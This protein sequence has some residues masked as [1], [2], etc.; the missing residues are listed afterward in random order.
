VIGPAPRQAGDEGT[1]TAFVSWGQVSAVQTTIAPSSVVTLPVGSQGG[2]PRPL[3]GDPART[4][5][6]SRILGS[7]ILVASGAD[8][9]VE[10]IGATITVKQISRNSVTQ[11]VRKLQ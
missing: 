1:A 9:I 11:G 10:R 8:A 2:P 6:D 5:V 7:R 4:V 3:G